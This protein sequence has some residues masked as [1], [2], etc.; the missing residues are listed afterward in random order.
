MQPGEIFE[1]I[2]CGNTDVV[3]RALAERPDLA[4]ERQDHLG[5]TPLHFAAHRGLAEIVRALLAAGADVHAIERVSGTTALHWCA[6]GGHAGIARMLLEHGAEISP[7][8]EWFRLSPLGW[9]TVV[10]WAPR[11]HRDRAGTAALLRESG[12][13]DDVFTAL[14]AGDLALLSATVESDRDSVGR[15]LGFVY[16][17]MQPLHLAVL[18]RHAAAMS[19]LLESGADPNA[20]TAWGLTPLALARL[21]GDEALAKSLADAGGAEAD[22]SVAVFTGRDLPARAEPGLCAHLLLAAT[23]AARP[24]AVRRL[25]ALGADPNASAHH[26][27]GERP[28]EVTALHLA[29]EQGQAEIARALLDA[30]ARID[31]GAD[32]GRPTPLHVAA[33]AGHVEL[34]QLLLARGA[35]TKVVESFFNATPAGWAAHAENAEIVALLGGRDG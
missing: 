29:A 2:N 1:Q 7:I 35:D 18:R 9:A 31:P 15:R 10:T 23:R 8:D 4:H 3:V 33:G 22:L 11:F 21:A 28:A 26:L 16:G 6:E 32:D 19:V 27:I 25:L 5:S 12:A 17:E 30:G 20:R 13:R 14:A 34:V 24:D